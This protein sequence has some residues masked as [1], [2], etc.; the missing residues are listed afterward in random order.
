MGDQ[1]VAVVDTKLRDRD[2]AR[3][4]SSTAS[5]RKAPNN[6]RQRQKPFGCW[7]HRFLFAVDRS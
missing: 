2:L 1:V 6:T 5:D 3:A 7:R 4:E